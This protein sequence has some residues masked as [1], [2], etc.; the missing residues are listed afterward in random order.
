[1][2]RRAL[3][4]TLFGRHK[5][6]DGVYYCGEIS[7]TFGVVLRG[8]EKQLEQELDCLILLPCER[9]YAVAR[10]M[11]NAE[12]QQ[13]VAERSEKAVVEV[14]NVT[15]EVGG[16]GIRERHSVDREGRA[17]DNARL[18]HANK[19]AVYN[20]ILLYELIEII[21]LVVRMIVV[22][23]GRR[24]AYLGFVHS[25]EVGVLGEKASE[26]KVHKNLR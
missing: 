20:D 24:G 9:V 25:A 4:D 1:M 7:A 8:T 19:L 26:L 5:T 12:W 16:R 14:E 15:L 23:V 13:S 10:L 18:V 3:C 21:E 17:Y 2:A 11:K 22:V 6:D